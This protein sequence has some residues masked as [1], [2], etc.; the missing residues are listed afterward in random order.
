[1][2]CTQNTPRYP[3]RKTHTLQMCQHTPRHPCRKTHTLQMHQQEHAEND[4]HENPHT[5][6]P[7]ATDPPAS[8]THTHRGT[9]T[10][11]CHAT[12]PPLPAHSHKPVCPFTLLQPPGDTQTHACP[13]WWPPVPSPTLRL[14]QARNHLPRQL[15]TLAPSP[16]NSP[17]RGSG[18]SLSFPP[19]DSGNGLRALTWS[20]QTRFPAGLPVPLLMASTP[21]PFHYQHP[22]P[23]PCTCCVGKRLPFPAPAQPP[24]SWF[25][26]IF[27]LEAFHER[28]SKPG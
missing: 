19:V 12:T 15:L 3:R 6:A 22:T 4:I 28:F 2:G 5:H 8:P 13:C 14:V 16:L 17:L 20:F 9:Q 24:D 1:M 23:K 21:H 18:P 25:P 10:T 11:H 27:T 26:L 7:L